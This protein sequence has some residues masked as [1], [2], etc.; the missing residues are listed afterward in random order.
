MSKLSFD[1]NP[2]LLTHLPQLLGKPQ[3]SSYLLS[4]F[5]MSLRH[6]FHPIPKLSPYCCTYFAHSNLLVFIKQFCLPVRVAVSLSLFL[7]FNVQ[8]DPSPPGRPFWLSTSVS[9]IYSFGSRAHLPRPWA[10]HSLLAITIETEDTFLQTV[11]G[12]EADAFKHVQMGVALFNQVL[13]LGLDREGAW[14]RLETA[15]SL[16]PNTKKHSPDPA[17]WS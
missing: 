16:I 4:D 1:L 13:S 5:R 2:H 8:F 14:L 17:S 7:S 12:H 6:S 9:L 15:S 3:I 10:E 11:Q